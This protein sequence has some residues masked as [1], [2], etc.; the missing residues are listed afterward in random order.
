M[1]L[2]VGSRSGVVIQPSSS[3]S[4]SFSVRTVTFIA[5]MDTNSARRYSSSD[6]DVRAVAVSGMAPPNTVDPPHVMLVGAKLLRIVSAGLGRFRMGASGGDDEINPL[7]VRGKLAVNAAATVE[8][9]R[10]SGR[11]LGGVDRLCVWSGSARCSRPD[12]RGG[13]SPHEY[14][15]EPGSPAQMTSSEP[16]ESEYRIGVWAVLGVV[17][18][19]LA[20]LLACRFHS[21]GFVGKYSSENEGA[22]M[23]S[24]VSGCVRCDSAY[25]T[26]SSA[27]DSPNMQDSMA[28]IWTSAIF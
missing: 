2:R 24:G 7:R 25:A 17:M 26:L 14:E 13:V 22:F 10:R 18:A 1:G 9:E 4:R 6:T 28:S 16:C 5:T 20:W 15:L 19:E 21:S 23:G 12:F 27:V 8:L 11:L 3:K